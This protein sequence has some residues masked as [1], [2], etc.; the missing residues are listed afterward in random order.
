MRTLNSR[1]LS[2]SFGRRGIGRSLSGMFGLG[3]EGE[4]TLVEQRQIELAQLRAERQAVEDEIAELQARAA[5]LPSPKARA[6]AAGDAL[7]DRVVPSEPSMLE[8]I[9]AAPPL[10]LAA[11]GIAAVFVI[12]SITKGRR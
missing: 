8:Q 4:T 3:A 12:R 10:A 2:Q 5:G 7:M 9:Q 6:A 1:G 11:A